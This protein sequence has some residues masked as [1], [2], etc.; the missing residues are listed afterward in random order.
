MM[1]L[2]HTCRLNQ[3]TRSQQNQ[4]YAPSGKQLEEKDLLHCHRAIEFSLRRDESYL[5]WCL[6]PGALQHIAASLGHVPSLK[7]QRTLAWS[8]STKMLIDVVE[9][10]GNVKTQL[11]VRSNLK[12]LEF[13]RS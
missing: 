3:E 9:S 1:P 5:C 13:L 10:T 12:W 7:R 11:N 2:S 8:I 6:H 4:Q